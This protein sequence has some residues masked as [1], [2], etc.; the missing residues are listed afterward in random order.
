MGGFADVA[1]GLFMLF[2][3]YWSSSDRSEESAQIWTDVLVEF[4][5]IVAAIVDEGVSSGEFKPVDAESLVWALLAAYDG[6]AAYIVLMPDMDLKRVSR[7]F[8][9][10][11]LEGLLADDQKGPA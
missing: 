10:T 11:L 6:L 4:K 5:D 1:E 9:G 8:V 2:L 7:A 3:G